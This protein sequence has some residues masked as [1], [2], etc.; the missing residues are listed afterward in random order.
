MLPLGK[1]IMHKSNFADRI[2]SAVPHR[3]TVDDVYMGY[4][5][6]A[7]TLVVGNTWLLSSSHCRSY[8]VLT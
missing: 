8:V 5:L 4:D 7:G 1:N 3:L 6:P 2:S